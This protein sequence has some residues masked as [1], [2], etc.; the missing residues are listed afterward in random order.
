ML[1]TRHSTV[2][3]IVGGGAAALPVLLLLGG[4]SA[5]SGATTYTFTTALDSQRDGLEATR[6]AAINAS[7]TV[8]VQVRDNVL[9]ISKLITKRGAEDAPVVVVDTQQVA[10]FPTF[11]DN[12]ITLIPSDPSINDDG[13]VAFQGNLRRLTTATRTE[14]ATPEQRQ[15]RQGVF[16]GTG[17]PLTTIAHTINQPGGDFIAEFVVADQSV[18]NDG[19]VAFVPELH[20][21]D[22]GLFVG[23]GTAAYETRFLTSGGQFRA[24][25]SRVSL[26][27][28]GQIA[29]ED[30][31][32]FLSNPDGTFTTI[33]GRNS[34]E[35]GG[36]GD[37]S[38]N[39][40]GRVAFLGS[41]FVD[42]IQILGV[43]TSQG[44]PATTV[45]DSSGPYA[46][47]REPSLNN[48]GR[49][50][51]TADLDE[52]SPDGRQIQGVFTGPNPQ[53][54][55]VLQTGDLYE[56]VPVTSVVTCS[57]ALNNRGEI[58]M[59]VQSED[60]Q[61]FDVRTFIVKARPR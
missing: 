59:T 3:R 38:L 48:S 33:V 21:F 7:G 18:N 2:R 40:D 54:D 32:I 53:T 17:G 11:C 30:R 24:P 5:Q 27:E 14:C 50:V 28:P 19:K 10:D 6:C 51:F 57:E 60:P 13:Q 37:A 52:F 36:V 26:N 58:V 45:A 20:D 46:S 25:S 9:G 56:G 29:F 49:V 12:G 22:Q 41:K 47:F 43:Y 44:G 23:S 15:R 4:V 8:A 16:L 61:T 31:G 1:C 55:K 42:D 39:N 35:F 34:P